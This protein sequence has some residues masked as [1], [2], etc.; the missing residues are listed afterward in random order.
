MC[1]YELSKIFPFPVLKVLVAQ[2]RPTLCNP[3]GCGLPGSS[4]LG[5]L[6]ARILGWVAISF[7]GDLPDPGIK[8]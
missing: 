8:L 4:V 3:M 6:Q 1:F 7:P 5:F 2:S